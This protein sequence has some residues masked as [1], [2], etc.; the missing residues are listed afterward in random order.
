MHSDMPRWQEHLFIMLARSANDATDYFQI[1][2]DRVV[3]VGTQ[4]NI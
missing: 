3:E 1:P 2:T 4:V